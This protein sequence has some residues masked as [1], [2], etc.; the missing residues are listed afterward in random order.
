MKTYWIFIIPFCLTASLS[1]QKQTEIEIDKNAIYLEGE[2]LIAIGNATINYERVLNLQGK[3]HFGISA[4]IGPG[5]LIESG[6]SEHE[7]SFYVSTGKVYKIKTNIFWNSGFEIS[8]GY[9]LMDYRY[10][11]T[12]FN[13]R[14]INPYDVHIHYPI[15]SIGYRPINKS[16]LFKFHVGTWGLGLCLGYAF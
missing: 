6:S 4:G 11:G 13:G 2:F 14:V 10:P 16:F 12:V 5:Y 3:T 8:L 7:P 1:A 9:S 15:V